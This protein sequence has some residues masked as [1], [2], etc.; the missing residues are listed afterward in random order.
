M[1]HPRMHAAEAKAV[2]NKG[3]IHHDPT[4]WCDRQIESD[5]DKVRNRTGEPCPGRIA[6][7]R[8]QGQA[9]LSERIPVVSDRANGKD[10]RKF[11]ERLR[12][13]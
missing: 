6:K 1:I 2:A 3:R 12:F 7:A 4:A 10:R 9:G 11:M 5:R 8:N 13:S